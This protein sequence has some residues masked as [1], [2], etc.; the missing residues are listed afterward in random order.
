GLWN[1]RMIAK[2]NTLLVGAM[3]MDGIKVFQLKNN[4]WDTLGDL[5]HSD[6]I[7]FSIDYFNG[8]PYSA[9][10]DLRDWNND[11]Q[12]DWYHETKAVVK[13]YQ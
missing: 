8:V 6:R 7:A 1:T 4:A 3:S 11:G 12:E 10:I 13:K 9:V 5:V 2:E